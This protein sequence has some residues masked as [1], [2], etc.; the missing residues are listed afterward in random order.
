VGRV[1]DATPTE[2]QDE[3]LLARAFGAGCCLIQGYDEKARNLCNGQV[4]PR[5]TWPAIPLEVPRTNQDEAQEPARAVAQRANADSLGGEAASLPRKAEI[6]G[7]S[8][9]VSF[10]ETSPS[11]T[12][13]EETKAM[14]LDEPSNS[15]GSAFKADHH[16][17]PNTK[18]YRKGL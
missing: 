1:Y 5:E 6:T 12:P 7:G 15:S 18:R 9:S 4:P 3:G 16:E 14:V 10:T 13:K 2:L 11:P 8:R 17:E